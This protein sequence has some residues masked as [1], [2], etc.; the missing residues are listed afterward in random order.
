MCQVYEVGRMQAADDKQV[1]WDAQENETL[2][3]SQFPQCLSPG[4]PQG[5]NLLM[6]SESQQYIGHS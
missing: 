6:L 1:S 2:C 3:A 5:I 4:Q